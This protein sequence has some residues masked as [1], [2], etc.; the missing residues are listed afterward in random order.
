MCIRDRDRSLDRI[1]AAGLFH[2]VNDALAQRILDEFARVLKP[3][4]RVVV[5]EAIW[6]RNRCNL[7]G[8]F[9]R[10]MDEGKHVRV[11]EAYD[12]L[13]TRRF[14]IRSRSFPARLGLDYLLETLVL[15]QT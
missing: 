13:F 1:L 5:F 11:P 14:A 3:D 10:R 2:H 6:P 12:A 4:G 8:A 9:M 7:F 15:K